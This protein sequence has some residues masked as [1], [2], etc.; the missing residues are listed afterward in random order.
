MDDVELVMEFVPND[1]AMNSRVKAKLR[2]G[3]EGCE[4]ND[5]DKL[6]RVL[7]SHEQ[8]WWRSQ[9][10]FPHLM[11]IEPLGKDG[12]GTRVVPESHTRFF[13]GHRELTG[14][15]NVIVEDMLGRIQGLVFVLQGIVRS[16]SVLNR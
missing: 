2:G 16:F 3:G 10:G 13:D 7:Q 11:H 4:E 9:N 5:L 15:A 8:G 1:D 12:P 14:M 6:V